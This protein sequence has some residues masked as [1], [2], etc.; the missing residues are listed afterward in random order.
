MASTQWEVLARL[1]DQLPALRRE[2]A[3]HSNAA[4]DLLDRIEDG[5]RSGRPVAALLDELEAALDDD[6]V[7]GGPPRLPNLPPQPPSEERFVC[8]DGRC[9]REVTP[10][11]AGPVPRCWL[12][13]R[14]MRLQDPD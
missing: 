8:P 13:S 3:E 10:L 12:N 1:C 14:L 6:E 9:G 5:A 7:R 4:E 2:V 11:P